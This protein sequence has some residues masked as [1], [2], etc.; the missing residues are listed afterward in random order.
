MGS[1]RNDVWAIGGRGEPSSIIM[2]GPAGR[3][4]HKRCTLHAIAGSGPRDIWLVTDA[5]IHYDGK[6]TFPVAAAYPAQVA[7]AL[8]FASGDPG[9]LANRECYCASNKTSTYAGWR[10]LGCN[11]ICPDRSGQAGQANEPPGRLWIIVFC[12]PRSDL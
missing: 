5:L 8:G 3:Q 11:V 12:T 9:C 4:V 10:V 1:G 6:T 7:H 2:T